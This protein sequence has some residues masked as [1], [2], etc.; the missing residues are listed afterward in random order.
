MFV[1]CQM[2]FLFQVSSGVFRFHVRLSLIS[3]MPI[4]RHRSDKPGSIDH[5]KSGRDGA[6]M[7]QSIEKGGE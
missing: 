2:R 7:A 1:V 3:Q 6:K 4:F 5:G